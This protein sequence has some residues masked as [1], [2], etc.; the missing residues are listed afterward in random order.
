MGVFDRIDSEG[1][2]HGF[3]SNNSYFN[4]I[5][6]TDSLIG[7]LIS[8]VYA[9]EKTGNEEWMVIVTSDHGGH[10]EFFWGNH[11]VIYDEDEV[12]PFG[13]T[14]IGSDQKLKNFRYPVT[15]MDTH[16]TVMRWLGV[17]FDSVD[18][19]VQGIE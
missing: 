6:A 19:K 9:R 10:R 16:P 3:D 7:P 4:A 11:G 13:M 14:L 5:S 12:I 2:A 18:G 17:Q 15:H 8:A 1:H